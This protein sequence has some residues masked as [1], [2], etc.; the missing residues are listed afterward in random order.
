MGLLLLKPGRSRTNRD[1]LATQLRRPGF[2]VM[3]GTEVGKI[4]CVS[5]LIL[6][7]TQHQKG[8]ASGAH[9]DSTPNVVALLP[10]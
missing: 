9:V 8:V 7:Y 3:E 1:K 5:D 4:L 2:F 10:I 6:A